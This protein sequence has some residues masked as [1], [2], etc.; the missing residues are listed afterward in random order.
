MVNDLYSDNCHVCSSKY[1]LANGKCFIPTTP[2]CV[3]E[4]DQKECLVCKEST[5]NTLKNDN[6]KI[7]ANLSMRDGAVSNNNDILNS[8]SA[9]ACIHY[10]TFNNEN[11]IADTSKHT[12][13][14]IDSCDLHH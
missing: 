9:I 14:Y 12:Q 6:N 3:Y 8:G 1:S 10:N 13:G 5:Y 7:V 2:F 4:N 11:V